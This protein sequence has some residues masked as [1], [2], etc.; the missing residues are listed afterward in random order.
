MNLSKVH[1]IAFFTTSNSFLSCKT[2]TFVLILYLWL[3]A[4]MLQ[5][6][7]LYQV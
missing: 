3:V 5:K 7:T 4:L 6:L 2:K 1:K